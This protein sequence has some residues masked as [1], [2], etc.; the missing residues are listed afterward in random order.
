MA[1]AQPPAAA[2]TSG[3]APVMAKVAPK[4]SAPAPSAPLAASHPY[5]GAEL[6]RIGILTAVILAILFALALISPRF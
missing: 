6:L 2:Q 3:T 5:V 1:A 4:A